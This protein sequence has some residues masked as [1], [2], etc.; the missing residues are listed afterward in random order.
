[1]TPR[2]CDLIIRNGRVLTMN[3]TRTV[4]AVGA[5]ALR[6]HSIAAVGAERDILR[7]WRA[8]RIIDAGGGLVHPGFVDAHLHVNAQ[9]CRGFFRGDTSKGGSAGPSY[10][11]W[12]AEL[13]AEDEQA[14]A[15]LAC[16]EMLRHGITTFVEPGSAF[17]PDAVAAATQA[18]GM[19]CSLADPYLWDDTEM[20]KAI[21][22]LLSPSLA[23][24]V[25]PDRKRCEQLLG[26]QLFRNRDRDG[27]LHGHVAL[28]G[29]GTS[30]DE[31]WRAAKA[32]A[33]REGVIV[34][35]HIGFDLTLAAAMEARWKKPR[36]AY[37]AELGVLGRNTTF[38]HMNLIRDAEVDPIL[39]SGLSIVWCPFAYASRGTPLRQPTR[40]PE[41]KRRGASVAL[42]TDSARQSSAGDAGFLAFVLAAECGT[43]L[44]SEEIVEMQTIHGARAA[45]LEPLI[46]SL[47]PGKRADIVIRATDSAELS[48]GLDPAH[49]L[50][51]VGHGPSVDT[52]LVNGIVVMRHGRSTRLDETEV[53]AAAQASALR[54]AARLGVKPTSIWP[55]Q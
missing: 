28:Y 13:R 15:A 54:V 55:V 50:I 24:R 4:F 18:A 3:A 42:G 20:M 16:I 37:L 14:A 43:G 9:T 32:L 6:G 29:E 51:A 39:S 25:A 26:G 35:T 22:G 47:E 2:T 5:I 27:I 53:F 52:A 10:A 34:N 11:D 33:D 21:P 23:K 41:M 12:K 31:L 17:E 38:V 48:P 19:R 46:G 36:F 45:G 1:M 7:D 44:G 8:A 30:S 40:L 49:Q